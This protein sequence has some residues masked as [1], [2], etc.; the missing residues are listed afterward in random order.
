MVEKKIA[1]G[2]SNSGFAHARTREL[3]TTTK[4]LK[5][6]K[7][8]PTPEITDE[9]KSPPTYIKGKENSE[10]IPGTINH[11][12]LTLDETV[13]GYAEH[14]GKGQNGNAQDIPPKC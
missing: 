2:T 5:K 10:H 8:I 3:K 14:G 9:T 7:K 6:I 4:P 11:V 1:P 13:A 12:G